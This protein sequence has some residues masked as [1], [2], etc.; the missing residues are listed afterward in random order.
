[1]VASIKMTVF[2]HVAHLVWK[3]LIDISQ[4]LTASIRT[5]SNRMMKAVSTAETSV[6]FYQTT[7]RNIPEGSQLCFLLPSR[8]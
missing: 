6:N 7:P 8:I 1:M 3:K 5:M 2:W 4:V